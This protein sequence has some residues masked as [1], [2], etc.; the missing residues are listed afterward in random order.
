MRQNWLRSLRTMLFGRSR[1]L[2]VQNRKPQTKR[3]MML[4]CLEDR[5]APAATLNIT[6]TVV[7]YTASVGTIVNN[8]TVSVSGSTYTFNDTGETISLT[9]TTTGWTGSGTNTVT[10]PDSSITSISIGTD[11]GNDIV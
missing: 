10:G 1:K 3:R 11:D 6:G 9:G 4:E 5:L 7:T 8:L 2:P